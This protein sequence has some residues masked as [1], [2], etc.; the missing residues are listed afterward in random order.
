MF[1]EVRYYKRK[2]S[3]GRLDWINIASPNFKAE[4][5]HL[6]PKLVQKRMH[7]RLVSGEVVTGVDAFIAI[8]KTLDGFSFYAKLASIPFIKPILELAYLCF[9]E[10]RP[11]LPKRR[12][13]DL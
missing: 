5:Y 3:A 9:A 1:P 6:D 10:L 12:S 8:W 4:S 13:C 7:A 2:D 11:F